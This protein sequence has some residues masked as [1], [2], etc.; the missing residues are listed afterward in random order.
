MFNSEFGSLFQRKK[1][2]KPLFVRSLFRC[3]RAFFASCSLSS[4]VYTDRWPG[5]GYKIGRFVNLRGYSSQTRYCASNPYNSVVHLL[6]QA[7]FQNGKNITQPPFSIYSFNYFRLKTTTI[8]Y[9]RRSSI[10]CMA[11]EG[12]FLNSIKCPCICAILFL[13][14]RPIT[15]SANSSARAKVWS[16]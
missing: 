16:G 12:S 15:L 4:L 11:P 13:W 6:V 9:Y 10:L 8:T 3:S 1:R 14:P 2:K 7:F 5:T